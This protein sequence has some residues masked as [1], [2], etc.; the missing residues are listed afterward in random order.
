MGFRFRKSMKLPGGYRVNVSNS[1]V[2]YSWGTKGYR[3]TKTAK[4]TTRETITIPGTGI[5]HVRE[6]KDKSSQSS[7]AISDKSKSVKQRHGCLPW[8]VAILIALFAIVII[9]AYFRS[10]AKKTDAGG[11]IPVSISETYYHHIDTCS[12]IEYTSYGKRI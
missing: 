12:D 4:G 5:S 2:G 1:G 11:N 7:S 3:V 8:I 10:E 9:L 6:I